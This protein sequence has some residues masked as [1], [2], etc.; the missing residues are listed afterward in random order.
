[1]DEEIVGL[2]VRLVCGEP[3]E[4]PVIGVVEI[5]GETFRIWKHGERM[6]VETLE[7]ALRSIRERERLLTFEETPWA[8]VRRPRLD[9]LDLD[10][11]RLDGDVQQGV[12][13]GRR[14][15][16]FTLPGDMPL[17]LVLDAETGMP[18]EIAEEAVDLSWREL[19]FVDSIDE[20]LLTWTGDTR[21]A[22]WF[23]YVGMSEGEVVG[24]SHL[25]PGARDELREMFRRN[26]DLA[27]E[28]DLP[29]MTGTVAFEAEVT[30][31][32]PDAAGIYLTADAHISVEGARDFD[33][34]HDPV[35]DVVWTTADGWTWTVRHDGFD[36]PALL[37][38]LREQIE[39][40]RAGRGDVEPG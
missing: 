32:G 34:E 18:F 5:E 23:A 25:P 12:R 38:S 29:E 17:T 39:A 9:M 8:R 6:R 36:D 11:R 26:A 33:F 28:L 20:E 27:R 30:Y 13:F 19:E 10:D 37:A 16:T 7:G 21:A 15:A 1:M 35:P 2:L 24:G 4:P 40:W 31:R 22:G 3:Y 14:T